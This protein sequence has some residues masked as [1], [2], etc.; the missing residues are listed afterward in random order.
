MR[1]LWCRVLGLSL[2]F[3]SSCIIRGDKCDAHQV[4]LKKNGFVLCV[5]AANAVPDG[6]GYGCTPCGANA[7]P[8]ED[9][10]IC[11]AG[12]AK[13]DESGACEPSELGAACSAASDCAAEYPYCAG[14][15]SGGGFCTTSGCGANADC[16]GGWTCEREGS[17]RYCK[18]PPSGL[19][20]AC[21]SNEDCASF[22]AKL[23]DTLQS[24]QCLLAGCATG[25]SVCP[26]E[27]ACCDY[28]ALA[29]R[30]FSVCLDAGRLDEGKCPEN[31]VLVTP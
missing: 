20:S 3:A 8:H 5:C 23:C 30:A 22:D 6:R 27:W 10:C 2:L 4:E 29:M 24:H 18:T 15:G 31:G 28:S 19:G 16:E 11:K 14:L 25:D 1:A 17:E 13:D 7:E 21:Q 12:F 9:A 26:N